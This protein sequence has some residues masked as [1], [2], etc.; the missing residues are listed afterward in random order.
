MLGASLD[1]VTLL[2]YVPKFLRSVVRRYRRLMPDPVWIDFEEFDTFDPVHDALPLNCFELIAA[3]FLA[4]GQ[5]AQG[6][7][8]DANI[9][10]N[11]LRQN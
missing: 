11:S 5:G 2:R 1:T 10:S 4:S 3:E 7:V 6:R 9:D 8:A